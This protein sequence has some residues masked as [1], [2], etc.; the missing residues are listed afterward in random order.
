[1]KKGRRL[2][3]RKKAEGKGC[4]EDEQID[5][6]PDPHFGQ[7]IHRTYL[8]M[9]VQGAGRTVEKTPEK[10]SEDNVSPMFEIAGRRGDVA[11]H[12]VSGFPEKSGVAGNAQASFPVEPGHL[13]A[14]VK[15]VAKGELR[16][17]PF[18]PHALE[19]PD[20]PVVFRRTRWEGVGEPDPGPV[21]DGLVG[22]GDGRALAGCEQ[23]DRQESQRRNAP[24]PGI[25][26]PPDRGR[27]MEN[28]LDSNQ[29]DGRQS[30]K[31]C[32]ELSG[33]VSEPLP[34]FDRLT[35]CHRMQELST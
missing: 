29:F 4:R 12:A 31:V 27:T 7:K 20:H 2:T 10:P 5:G 24:S 32:K 22:N 35:S 25:R 9:P 6:G 14:S 8:V 15:M 17:V 18:E 30:S 34:W 3:V 13:V 19:D 26:V 1:M 21:Q 11:S 33:G 23:E 16:V 28:A